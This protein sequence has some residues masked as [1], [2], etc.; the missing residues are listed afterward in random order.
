M[1]STVGILIQ[2]I[3]SS[4]KCTMGPCLSLQP[5]AVILLRD[6]KKKKTVSMNSIHFLL[7]CCYCGWIKAV[8]L[9]FAL[10]YTHT[11]GIHFLQTDTA[12]CISSLSVATR[13]PC[14]TVLTQHWET[15]TRRSCQRRAKPWDGTMHTRQ[16]TQLSAP[17]TVPFRTQ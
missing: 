3:F 9:R 11:A 4:Q 7:A 13:A 8:A 16:I 10:L 6:K 15:Q 2:F 1:A 14:K 17:P 5:P 12:G